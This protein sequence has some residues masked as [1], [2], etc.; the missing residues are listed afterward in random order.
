MGR[1][2]TLGTGLLLLGAGAA[3]AQP[4]APVP[5]ASASATVSSEENLTVH[6]HRRRFETAPMPGAPLP[7]PPDKPPTQLGRYKISGDQTPK[8]GYD[9]QTGAY[10][11]PFG[12]A[13]TGASPTADGLASRFQ[14]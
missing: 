8:D 12:N 13:Y 2:W 9:T 7:P 14:H 5:Q 1:R 3:R 6:G 11:A 4:A 10:I